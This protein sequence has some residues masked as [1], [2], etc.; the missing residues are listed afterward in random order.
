MNGVCVHTQCLFHVCF[1]DD[2]FLCAAPLCVRSYGRRPVTF[3]GE[4]VGEEVETVCA[5]APAGQL[6]RGFFC[7]VVAPDVVCCA[8]SFIGGGCVRGT[9]AGS[10][11][12]LENVRFHREEEGRG[13]DEAGKV[14][15]ATAEEVAAFRSSLT[16]LGDVYVNDAFGTAHRAHSSMVGVELQQ[17]VS[18]LLLK[19]EL[20]YFAKDL[21]EPERPF[22]A[23][24]GGF[25]RVCQEFCAHLTCIYV[26]IYVCVCLEVPFL[27][28]FFLFL[29]GI[30][31][32]VPFAQYVW[33]VQQEWSVLW[34]LIMDIIFLFAPPPSYHPE[35]LSL[36]PMCLT[37]MAPQ[38]EG[39]RQNQAH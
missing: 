24:M 22:L 4:C 28:G 38:S 16:R 19:K 1:D 21:V 15:K 26:C 7:C 31:L 6:A 2:W 11:I 23:I 27:H 8:P 20:D 34:L 5:Q 13:V 12:L 25:V 39:Q 17:R 37:P 14:V 10:V 35:F 3:V 30:C 36:C 18:G 9:P 33:R 32:K 29:G